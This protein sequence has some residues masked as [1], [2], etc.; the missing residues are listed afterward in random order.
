[1][2]K[3]RFR[4]REKAEAPIWRSEILS[5]CKDVTVVVY[6]Q[7]SIIGIVQA[8]F[9]GQVLCHL[10]LAKSLSQVSSVKRQPRPTPEL[11][12]NCS[13]TQ[14]A[15]GD[16]REQT[17]SKAMHPRV[18]FPPRR[19]DKLVVRVNIVTSLVPTM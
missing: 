10:E 17:V 5:G 1:M 9:L 7:S 6:M 3:P 8:K 2:L 18:S 16:S 14:I 12:R 11:P 13:V 4:L 19:S 15:E